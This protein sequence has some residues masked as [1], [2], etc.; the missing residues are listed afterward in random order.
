MKVEI[1]TPVGVKFSG[2]AAGVRAPGALGELGI[3]PGHRTMMAALRTGVCIVAVPEKDPLHLVIDAGYVHVTDGKNVTITTELCEGW[4]DID[5]AVARVDQE[6]AT[7]AL[8]AIKDDISTLLWQAR[9]HDLD[10][11]ETRLRVAASK[12]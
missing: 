7:A 5:A 1:V 8:S 4:Q 12:S 10:L 2:E 3:L 9:R 6:K 11:A